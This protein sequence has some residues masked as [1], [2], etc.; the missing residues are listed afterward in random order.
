MAPAT[1]LT[2]VTQNV[3]SVANALDGA[4]PQLT[5]QG[6][7]VLQELFAALVSGGQSIGASIPFDVAIASVADVGVD[8]GLSSL[9]QSLAPDGNSSALD[10]FRREFKRELRSTMSHAAELHPQHHERS[11][12]KPSRTRNNA[13]ES[14]ALPRK[15]FLRL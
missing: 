15:P 4:L 9:D 1:A 8:Y 14:E 11:L 5:A 10:T 6:R 12:S 3:Q 13:S 7:I 2:Q